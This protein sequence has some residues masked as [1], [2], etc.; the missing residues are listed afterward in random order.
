MV[1][2]LLNKQLP[3]L[4]MIF[5]LAGTVY[6]SKHRP[7]K[8]VK[9]MSYIWRT[10]IKKI[11]IVPFWTKYPYFLH[12]MTGEQAGIQ[13][14]AGAIKCYKDRKIT[15]PPAPSSVCS[16]ISIMIM[17]CRNIFP[18]NQHL[19][20]EPNFDA[21]NPAATVVKPEQT[22]FTKPDLTGLPS[23][24]SKKIDLLHF[25]KGHQ[26]VSISASNVNAPFWIHYQVCKSPP[27]YFFMFDCYICMKL[28]KMK[29]QLLMK[30]WDSVY[31]CKINN[32]VI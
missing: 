7:Q 8:V 31:L 6:K 5:I 16:N 9:K 4:L 11:Q 19:P 13:S 32:V 24:D 12:P 1:F 28:A 21:S 2:V 3:I 23:P 22:S 15:V 20:Y 10:N 25:P 29:F 30:I 18:D 14:K 26:V 17:K 27:L